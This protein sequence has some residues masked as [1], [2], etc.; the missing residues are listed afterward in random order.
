MTRAQLLALE[1][2][3]A[4][5]ADNMLNAIEA[6]KHRPFWQLLF[7]L[8][9]RYAGAKTAQI[10]TQA[11][12]S[13]DQLLAASE[14]EI[15]SVPG[16]GPIVGHSLDTWLQDEQNHALIERLRQAG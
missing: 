3:K 6:S 14:A 12:G 9:I 1:G 4:N 11:F 5:S 13:M 10:I 7:V 16:I 2:V 15:T 8:N